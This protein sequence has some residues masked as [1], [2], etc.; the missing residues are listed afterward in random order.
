MT[1]KTKRSESVKK[2]ATVVLSLGVEYASRV[3]KYLHQDEIEQLTIE[4]A[5]LENLSA[6]AVETTMD[7]FYNLCLAQKFI[8]EGGIE[9]AKA[10]LEKAMGSTGAA[11]V[12]DKVT[13]SLQTK[14]FDFLYKADPKHLLSLIQNEHP[15]TIA[16]ILSYCTSEQ[17]SVILSELPREVQLDVVGRIATMD[18]T[19]PEV[20]KDIEKM[21][22]NKLSMGEAVGTTEIGGIK[23]MAEIL[24]SIDRG[25]E[26]FIMEELGKKDPKLAE[27]IRNKMFVFEDI[28]T[29]D[30]IYVQRFLQDVNTNDLLVALKGSNKEVADIFYANMSLRMKETMEEEAKY[31]HGVRIS[32]VEEAQQKLV[33]LVRKLEESGEVVISRGRRDEIIV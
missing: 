33:A 29:L 22:E 4:I 19:S 17:A 14:A 11:G 31:L 16:L 18:S 25:T 6:E 27:E 13:K 28:T 23:Y 24:N 32:D 10:I 12:I 15:Q 2:A 20:I 8:T 1:A 30:A 21:I 7:E 3:Y 26:K 9:Y 5:T